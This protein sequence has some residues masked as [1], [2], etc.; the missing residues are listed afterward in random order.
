MIKK[1]IFLYSFFFANIKKTPCWKKFQN[2]KM[3][4]IDAY[5]DE[6]KNCYVFSKMNIN[7]LHFFFTLANIDYSDVCH[8]TNIFHSGYRS[9]FTGDRFNS[10]YM[11]GHLWWSDITLY[12]YPTIQKINVKKCPQTHAK[13]KWI[14]TYRIMLL[15]CSHSKYLFRTDDHE[16]KI[17]IVSFNRKPIMVKI[18]TRQSTKKKLYKN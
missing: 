18:Q 7:I 16:K 1:P 8:W 12:L 13:K 15:H 6:N 17:I 5:L 3:T 9:P 2:I 10:Q 14:V 11:P 4:G